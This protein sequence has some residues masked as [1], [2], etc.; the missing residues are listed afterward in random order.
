M[1]DDSP[2]QVYVRTVS[3]FVPISDP[4]RTVHARVRL[5]G[6]VELKAVSRAISLTTVNSGR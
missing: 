3:G 2:K 4:A 6:E 1:A 5:G